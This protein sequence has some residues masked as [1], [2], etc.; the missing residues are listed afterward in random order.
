LRQALGLS[1]DEAHQEQTRYHLQKQNSMAELKGFSTY[2]SSHVA[3][4]LKISKPS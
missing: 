4:V 1:D 2:Q 3:L